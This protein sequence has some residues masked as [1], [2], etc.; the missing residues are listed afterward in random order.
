MKLKYWQPLFL[1]FSTIFHPIGMTIILH[2]YAFLMPN[3]CQECSLSLG[4][5]L[6][7]HI[8]HWNYIVADIGLGM[9]YSRLTPGLNSIPE[10]TSYLQFNR[11]N[12]QRNTYCIDFI[13]LF[14]FSEI[15]KMLCSS[16]GLN[17]NS[18][19]RQTNQ[20]MSQSRSVTRLGR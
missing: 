14:S 4:A 13:I 5:P 15:L 11:E 1:I 7:S 20:P 19:P 8:Q 12:K 2:L 9:I 6:Q 10:Y 3:H 17:I 18:W 16:S